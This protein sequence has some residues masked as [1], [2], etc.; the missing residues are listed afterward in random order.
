MELLSYCPD[1][2]ELRWKVKRNSYGGTVVPGKIAGTPAL[3]GY[4]KITIDQCQCLAHR[5]AWL[6]TTGE[7]PS[8][9]MEIDHINGNRSDNRIANLRVVDRSKNNMNS[10]IRG[11]NKSGVTGVSF[12]K[13]TEKWHA[14]ITVEKRIILLGNFDNIG[15]AIA[16]RQAAEVRYFGEYR[17]AA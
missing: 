17:R 1:T 16:A 6:I 7:L 12:R 5:L 8:A 10:C 11:N 15:E 3:H 4:I 9:G 13:D 2:G 14:R